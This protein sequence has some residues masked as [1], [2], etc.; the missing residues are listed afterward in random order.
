[1]DKFNYKVGDVV[2]FKG[3]S[4]TSKLISVFTNSP[5][6]H[7]AIASGCDD[8]VVEADF[9]GVQINSIAK[10]YKGIDYAVYRYLGEHR[11][12]Y[13]AYNYAKDKVGSKYD[14]FGLVGIGL[15]L[16]GI[17]KFNV[18]DEKDKY[19]CSELVADSYLMAGADLPVDRRTWKVSPADFA[20]MND[21]FKK[22]YE[23]KY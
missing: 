2:L 23:F 7:A 17:N 19:W 1:M 11:V 18:F 8:L 12:T 16:F 20:R 5:Y 13:D 10:K 15:Y 4:L 3:K 6:T 9:G 21:Y 14:Y 22:V